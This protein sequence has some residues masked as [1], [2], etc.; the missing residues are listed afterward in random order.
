M[1]AS[2]QITTDSTQKSAGKEESTLKS[3]GKT[4]QKTTQ[5]SSEKTTQKIVALI[6][7]NPNVT[8]EEM[9]QAIGIIRRNIA[10]NIKKLQEQ[11]IVRRVGPDKGGHWEIIK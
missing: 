11:G 10:K 3:S 7:A 5:K 2:A 1:P 4:T 6:K 8:T 9:A